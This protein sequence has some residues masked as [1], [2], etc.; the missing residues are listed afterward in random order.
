VVYHPSVQR[1]VGLILRHYDSVNRKLGDAF[2]D[3]LLRGRQDKLPIPTAA[4]AHPLRCSLG[5]RPLWASSLVRASR[6]HPWRSS[7]YV[8]YPTIPSVMQFVEAARLN[9]QRY[10]HTVG[11]LSR[12]NLKQFPYHFLFRT[13]AP[14]IRITVLRHHRRNPVYGISR[15]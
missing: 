7:L 5:Q 6:L 12:V 13:V 14:G 8:S 11:E 10:P 9:P 15:V 4:R 1:E 2:W 3:E